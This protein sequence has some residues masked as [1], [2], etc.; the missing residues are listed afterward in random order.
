MLFFGVSKKIQFLSSAIMLSSKST[1]PFGDIIPDL[2]DS[3]IRLRKWLN[4]PTPTSIDQVLS[5]LSNLSLSTETIYKPLCALAVF[6]QWKFPKKT[7]IFFHW[8]KR[9]SDAAAY[10]R[11]CIEHCFGRGSIFKYVEEIHTP[12]HFFSF[13][14][15]PTLQHAGTIDLYCSIDRNLQKTCRGISPNEMYFSSSPKL[16][17]ELWNM[18]IVPISDS[19]HIPVFSAE[20][21][22]N[23]NTFTISD[24]WEVLRQQQKTD[25]EEKRT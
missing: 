21:D 8:K 17:P 1:S 3:I 14:F 9:M 19:R 22:Q 16:Y 11:T 12:H 20:I 23:N 13:T 10:L 24:F 2:D 5:D 18:L 4:S 7:A 6:S 15:G 25:V